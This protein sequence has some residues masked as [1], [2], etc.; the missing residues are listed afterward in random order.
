MLPYIEVL[1]CIVLFRFFKTGSHYVV[2]AVLALCMDQAG[3]DLPT[4]ASQVL[5]SV[6]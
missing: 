5:G 6:P 2:L 3:L 1:V 4:S